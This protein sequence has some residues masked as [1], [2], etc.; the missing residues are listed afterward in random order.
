MCEFKSDLSCIEY[1]S[2]I[3]FAMIRKITDDKRIKKMSFIWLQDF[4]R[5]IFLCEKKGEGFVR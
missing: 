1:E 5:D 2:Y 3:V 4:T